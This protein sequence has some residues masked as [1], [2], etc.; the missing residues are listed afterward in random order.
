MLSPKSGDKFKIEGD[1]YIS[2][3]NS[4]YN[5]QIGDGNNQIIHIEYVK[6]T[7]NGGGFF[8]IEGE[9]RI[10]QIPKKDYS[11]LIPVNENKLVKENEEPTGFLFRFSKEDAMNKAMEVLDQKDIGYNELGVHLVFHDKF[12]PATEE[13]VSEILRGEDILDWVIGE[14]KGDIYLKSEEEIKNM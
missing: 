9:K 4:K 1:Y 10:F 7:P 5:R 14:W 8:R 6:E 12:G 2:Q 11:R 3:P 13:E